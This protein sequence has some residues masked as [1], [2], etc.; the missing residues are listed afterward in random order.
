[1]S[2]KKKKFGRH[3]HKMAHKGNAKNLERIKIELNKAQKD[4]QNSIQSHDENIQKI[5]AVKSQLENIKNSNNVDSNN[6]LPAIV[7]EKWEKLENYMQ[8]LYNYIQNENTPTT[9]LD[10]VINRILA[11]LEYYYTDIDSLCG[12]SKNT[13]YFEMQRWRSGVKSKFTSSRVITLYQK[14]NEVYKARFEKL[15]N[16]NS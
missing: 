4:L 10:D 2:K 6:E 16:V 12:W 9:Q 11:I 14:I 15:Y 13:L 8:T 5:Q 1:M 7:K 3:A